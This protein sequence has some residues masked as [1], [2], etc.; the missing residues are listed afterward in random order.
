MASLALEAVTSSPPPLQ[1]LS[2]ARAK[3][4]LARDGPN[5]LTPPPTTPEWVK[6]CR[7]VRRN[8]RY[9]MIQLHLQPHICPISLG[10]S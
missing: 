8:N 10:Y 6:F 7:Q 3:E 5:S 1:G 2:G 4:I 9:I